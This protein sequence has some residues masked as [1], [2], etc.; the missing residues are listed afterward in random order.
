METTIESGLRKSILNR[1]RECNPEIPL[2]NLKSG[3]DGVITRLTGGESIRCKMISLG[4]FPGK[5]I[6]VIQG[7]V[8]QPYLI[9][10]DDSR[11]MIDWDTLNKIYV[12]ADKTLA[13]KERNRCRWRWNG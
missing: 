7:T 6:S 1:S 13:N 11:V 4:I 5:K 3:N 8:S 2:F 12:Q 9:G 10:V